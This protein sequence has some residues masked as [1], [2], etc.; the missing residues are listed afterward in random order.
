M[1]ASI[2]EA[3]ARSVPSSDSTLRPPWAG[4]AARMR[5]G[6]PSVRATRRHARP[7]TAWARILVS[8]PAPKRSASSRG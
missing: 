1:I 4:A 8:R 5:S 2:E 3:S 6:T 7:D